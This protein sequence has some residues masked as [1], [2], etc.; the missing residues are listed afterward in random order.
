MSFNIEVPYNAWI[1]AKIASTLTVNMRGNVTGL[2]L[3]MTTPR[4]IE[5]QGLVDFSKTHNLAIVNLRNCS[6]SAVV[7]LLVS[8]KFSDLMLI[9][10][11]AFEWKQVLY[12][13]GRKHWTDFDCEFDSGTPELFQ[14]LANSPP[15]N[16]DIPQEFMGYKQFCANLY[17]AIVE[18]AD[19]VFIEGD[20][21][22]AK[23]KEND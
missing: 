4:V 3:D 20:D 14:W 21:Q 5:Y 19:T 17:R 15:G 10:S 9:H 23:L 11:I 18:E 13:H 12:A 6:N 7:S 1:A 8:K 22:T 16:T 2:S